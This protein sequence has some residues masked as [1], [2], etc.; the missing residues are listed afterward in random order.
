MALLMMHW[1]SGAP[2]AVWALVGALAILAAV[3]RI[4]LPVLELIKCDFASAPGS[5]ESARPLV[6]QALPG[7]V[8]QYSIAVG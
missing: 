8:G 6:G 5:A 2:G 4:H 3:I 1:D 7:V